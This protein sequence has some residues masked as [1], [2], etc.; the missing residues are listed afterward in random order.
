MS[1]LAIPGRI[2]SLEYPISKF[3]EFQK[4][5]ELLFA[6]LSMKECGEFDLNE[7]KSPLS[8]EVVERGNPNR[9][10][11]SLANATE[12]SAII[13]IRSLI[14]ILMVCV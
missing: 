11:I 13:G 6:G 14:F 1:S 4:I 10:L 5:L 3:D 7:P 2:F 12:V 8:I 9:A